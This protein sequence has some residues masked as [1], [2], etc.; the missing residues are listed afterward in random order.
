[1][2][3]ATTSW[4]AFARDLVRLDHGRPDWWDAV[5]AGVCAGGAVLAGW[6]AGDVA[7]GL[8]ASIGAFTA[9]YGNG[10]PFGYRARELGVVA[11]AM[12]AVVTLGALSASSV[13]L[14]VPVV[15]AVAVVATAL[16]RA[17]DTGPPGAYLFV[18]A[19][20]T[21]TAVP[22]TVGGPV[23]L[24]LLVL[25]GGA[26]AWVLHLAGVLAG[27]RRPEQD[28]LRAAVRAVGALQAAVGTAHYPAARDAAAR[29]M[30]ACWVALVAQQA[31]AT[32]PDGPLDRLRALALDLH[33]LM[34]E[35]MRDQDEGRSP[36]P[37]AGDRLAAL[38]ASVA[39]PPP[40]R[41]LARG[42]VPLGGPGAG[43]VLREL[44]A[45]GS[46][47]RAVLLRVGIAAL[48]AGAVGALAGL[49]HAYWAV[50]AAVL[51]L[52]QGLGWTGTLERAAL[53]LV[54][55]WLG[56]VVAAAVLATRPSGI[57]LVLVIAV[58]QG[59]V[60]PT[61][62]RNY[63]LGVVVVTP[64]ALTI[65]S[66]GHPA[67]LGALLLARG[68]DTAVGCALGVVVFLLVAPGTD[69]P[70]PATLVAA[71]LRDAARV[72]P[73]LAAGSTTSL[74]ARDAR[75]D[76]ARHLLALADAHGAAEAAPLGRIADTTVWW[77][78]LDAAR[79]LAHR[80]LA[81]C[82]AVD[83][84]ESALLPV[85]RADALTAELG[86]LAGTVEH[87]GTAPEGGSSPGDGTFA[88]ELAALRRSLPQVAT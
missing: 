46:P 71:S 82:W 18:L 88:P 29:A 58:L 45:P 8:I 44:L 15:A 63:G 70:P 27:P 47:W 86:A 61:M 4:R 74:P 54:G 49:D 22:G 50:A 37:D 9:L 43:R 83:R 20:A 87:G 69:R 3:A 48:A 65:G 59:A 64:L 38:A 77:P 79:H 73:H 33:A 57:A 66:A 14:A 56:L 39:D 60:Q 7:A 67:D 11:V 30:H 55:T 13:W 52:C 1:M 35:A 17:F 51:V 81:A 24:G 36:A 80:V 84:G 41:P 85:T 62:P 28:T 42:V 19:G 76:L 32:R 78:A 72:V 75:R 31:P 10:R 12:A 23:T 34:G 21:G 68:V 40:V 25:A 5:R 16:C 26:F 6:L 53:R 2:A